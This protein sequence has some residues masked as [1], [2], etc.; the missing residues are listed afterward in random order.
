MPGKIFIYDSESNITDLSQEPY[1]SE[2]YL[3]KLIADHPE[4]LAGDLIS[5]RNIQ[6]ES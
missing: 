2:D 4:I 3:Q 5:P 1:E 6:G